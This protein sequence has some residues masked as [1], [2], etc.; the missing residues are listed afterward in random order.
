MKIGV[1]IPCYKYHIQ[2]LKRC[3][4]SIESQEIKPDLVIVSCSSSESTDIPEEYK[5]IYSFPLQI[6]TFTKRQNASENRNIA[7]RELI[8]QGCTHISYFDCDD[9]MHP[10]RI[11]SISFAF[12]CLPECDIVLHAYHDHNETNQEF[13]NYKTVDIVLNYLR[14]APTGCAWLEFQTDARIHHSQSSIRSEIFEKVQYREGKEYERKEDSIFCG[15]VLSL[16]NSKNVY[17]RNYL[18]KYYLEGKWFE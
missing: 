13:I 6:L 11:K 18:S 10:Q 1:A 12:Q 3:L 9:V 8:S 2:K 15:D 4:D 7:S 17:I 14:R 5:K 16:P